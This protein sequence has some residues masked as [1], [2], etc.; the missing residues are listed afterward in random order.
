MGG[1]RR[2]GD[3][4][5]GGGKGAG[6]VEKEWERGRGIGGSRRAG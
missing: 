6:G 4:V 5:E 1:G 3:D 2:K